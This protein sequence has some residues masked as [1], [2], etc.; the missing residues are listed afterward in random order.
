VQV[1]SLD[2]LAISINRKQ[3]AQ[4]ILEKHG[5]PI[6]DEDA[7][8]DE[9]LYFQKLQIALEHCESGEELDQAVADI[10]AFEETL[11]ASQQE[12]GK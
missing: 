10:K 11:N 1:P 3:T 2:D 6:A 9:E 5:R 7:F 4:A 12:V 8:T